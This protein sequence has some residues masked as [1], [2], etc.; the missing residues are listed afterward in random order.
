MDADWTGRGGTGA[1]TRAWNP[2]ERHHWQ[3]TELFCIKIPVAGHCISVK[4]I[5]LFSSGTRIGSVSFAD[6]VNH[7]P[8]ALLIL[9]LQ[10]ATVSS[11]VLLILIIFSPL[12]P[13]VSTL[14][15]QAS[16]FRLYLTN[17]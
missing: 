4:P 11:C 15:L 1:M 5:S 14:R 16:I 9:V 2:G 10:L 12:G 13:D 17:I 3:N 8:V 6:F 7:V